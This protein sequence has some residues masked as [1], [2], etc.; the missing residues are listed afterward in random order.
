MD[1][2]TLRS[3]IAAFADRV[4]GGWFAKRVLSAD[5]LRLVAAMRAYWA[6]AS[7]AD[8]ARLAALMPVEHWEGLPQ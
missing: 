7:D 2:N 1:P 8:L 6:A 4:L 3:Q 5:Q